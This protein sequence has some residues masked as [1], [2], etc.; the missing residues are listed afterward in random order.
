M[1]YTIRSIH[2]SNAIRYVV[3]EVKISHYSDRLLVDTVDQVTMSIFLLAYSMMGK[4]M[5]M[6]NSEEN[7]ISGTL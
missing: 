5:A 2:F 4:P 7:T 3:T 6:K 1:K